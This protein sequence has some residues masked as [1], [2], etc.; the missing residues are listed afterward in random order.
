MEPKFTFTG[1]S[2]VAQNYEALEVLK[3]LKTIVKSADANDII[4]I[5]ALVGKKPG[6]VK[7]ALKFKDFI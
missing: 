3:A 1:N 6:A 4:E 7:K 5:G 2:I